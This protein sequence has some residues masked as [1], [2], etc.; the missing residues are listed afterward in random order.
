MPGKSGQYK[1]V[2]LKLSGEALQ[3]PHH[4]S[5]IDSVTVDRIAAELSHLNQKGTQ[6]GIVVGAG[7]FFRGISHSELG[8][9]RI[10]TDQMGMVSTVL[11]ALVLRAAIERAG[12][13]AMILSALP[14]NGIVEHYNRLKAIHALESGFITIFAG[15]TGNPLV[16]TDSAASLRS[17]EINADVLLKASNVDGIYSEDPKKNKNA[18]LYKQISFNDALKQELGVMDLTAFS[19]CRDY[20]MP[21]RVFNIH[22]ENAISNILSGKDEG[23]LVC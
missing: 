17:I 14:M 10:T 3:N 22:K 15:G 12:S 6:I 21:I 8:V 2:L 9:D 13:K 16:T 1:R 18:K 11:N 5:P 20:N 19:Q 7:N 23:S 4:T